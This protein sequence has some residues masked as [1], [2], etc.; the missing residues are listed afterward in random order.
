MQV[1]V[2]APEG[3]G[4]GKEGKKEEEAPGCNGGHVLHPGHDLAPKSIA[5]VIGMGGQDQ[6]HTLHPRLLGRH[7]VAT[8]S[9]LQI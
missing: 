2:S 4:Q 9:A 3:A 8:V 1:R 6:L 7:H 5:L